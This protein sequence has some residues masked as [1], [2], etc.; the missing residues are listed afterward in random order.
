MSTRRPGRSR[1]TVR[2]AAWAVFA[3]AVVIVANAAALFLWAGAAAA[4]VTVSPSSLPRGTADAILTFRVPNE[5]PTAAVT[6]LRVAFPLDHPIVIVSPES[7]SGWTV[8]V[9]RTQLPKP[10]T[11]DDGTFTSTVSE[12]DWG[13]G[14]I[15][16]GQFGAFSVLAQGFPS[17]TGRLVFKAVQEYGDGTT[18]SW[19]Q[20][21][22]QAAPNPAHPAPV[23]TLTVPGGAAI[24]ATSS[25][26]SAAAPTGTSSGNG[27]VLAILALIVAGLALVVAALAVWL[28]RPRLLTSAESSNHEDEVPGDLAARR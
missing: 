23:L 14:S 7:G 12:V 5:S 20:V 25:G 18:V 24:S 2:A 11:T 21:P 27:H 26:A 3:T 15:P 6:G 28:G 4:H 8:T 13:G 10:I 1:R 22:D 16:V 19:I 9:Q 17:G